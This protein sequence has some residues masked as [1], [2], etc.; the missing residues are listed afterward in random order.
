MLGIMMMFNRVV[1][2]RMLIIH[3]PVVAKGRKT[4]ETGEVWPVLLQR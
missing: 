1:R 3:N 4:R 2:L